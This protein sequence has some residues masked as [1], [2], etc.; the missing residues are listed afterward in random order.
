GVGIDIHGCQSSI[1]AE[2][3]YLRLLDNC[4]PESGS[5]SRNNGIET[6]AGPDEFD[7]HVL[8][9]SFDDDPCACRYPILFP[10][11][12]QASR[13]HLLRHAPLRC[14]TKNT[15]V[16]RLKTECDRL[17]GNERAQFRY[18]ADHTNRS[19]DTADLQPIEPFPP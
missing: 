14:A 8:I 4:F 15:E 1:G 16:P 6:L 2:H 5:P 17:H 10:S 7:R 13:N 12:P 3:R 11:F 18:D 19:A 9:W